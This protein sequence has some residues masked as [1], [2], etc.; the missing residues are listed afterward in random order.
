MDLDG[1]ASRPE[2]S[3]SP[4]SVRDRQEGFKALGVDSGRSRVSEGSAAP[5][6]RPNRLRAFGVVLAAAAVPIVVPA[7]S[8]PAGVPPATPVAPAASAVADAEATYGDRV[9]SLENAA[10]AKSGCAP[11]RADPAIAAAAAEHARDMAAKNYLGHSTPAGVS[12]WSRMKAA[13][14]DAP[15][16][17]NIGVGYRGPDKVV[18]GWMGDPYHRANI[19]NCSIKATGVGYF[20]AD[21]PGGKPWWTQDFGYR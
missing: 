7:A 14:Y 13:G 10:R 21:A 4:S 17:E 5:R 18:S 3:V 8:T 12:P 15:A 1:R 9:I 16:A 19:L 11:L 2:H 6:E 20:R